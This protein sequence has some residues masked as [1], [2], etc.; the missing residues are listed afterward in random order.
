MWHLANTFFGDHAADL[1]RNLLHV[2]FTDD[3]T[4]FDRDLFDDLLRHHPADRVRHLRHDGFWN[5]LTDGNRA[6]LTHHL[7]L[8][9]GAGDLSFDDVW[10]PDS[11]T[12]VES[13]HLNHADLWAPVRT[14]NHLWTAATGIVN[15]L[16]SPLATILFFR[17]VGCDR[18]HDR[19]ATFL[20]DHFR[21]LTHDGLSTFSLQ[22]FGDW[23]LNTTANF[24]SRFV[25]DLL[26]RRIGLVTVQ[27]FANGFHD[28]VAFFTIGRFVD[29]PGDL[30]LLFAIGDFV[31]HPLMCFRH[32][33]VRRF[34][35][36]SIDRVRLRLLNR[37]VDRSLTCL[38]FN[39][40]SRVT[41]RLLTRSRWAAPVT[42][43]TTIAPGQR[44]TW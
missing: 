23:S 39:T 17:A 33:L 22:R 5:H 21:L 27:S 16:L 25:P 13:R 34:I 26:L 18:S 41:A 15:L 9:R 11:F 6:G 37:F 30:V 2:L 40:V 43:G 32:I 38:P 14:R 10:A 29:L 44:R 31:D 36:G 7:R 4:G 24:A 3:T 1:I 28:R 8:V 35:D 12:S 19:V 20:V 42:G